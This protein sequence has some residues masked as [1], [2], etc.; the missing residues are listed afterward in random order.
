VIY[1]CVIDENSIFLGLDEVF[2]V[3]ERVQ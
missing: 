3:A 2:F 1:I